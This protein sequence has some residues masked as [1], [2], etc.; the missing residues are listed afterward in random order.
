M[1]AA[2]GRETDREKRFAIFRDAE[3]LLVSDDV[4]IC[5]LYYYVGIQFYDADRLG[6]IEA[7]LTDEHP[8][9]SMF[10]KTAR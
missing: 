6:G 4:P 7:N 5:P 2:A 8:I 9:K 10:W 1:I 3:K